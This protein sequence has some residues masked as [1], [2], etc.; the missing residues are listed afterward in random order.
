VK[1]NGDPL[2]LASM[3]RQVMNSVDPQVPIFD[4]RTQ[5]EQISLAIERE[6]TLA[7]LLAVF[8]IL[9]LSLA[10]VGIYGVISYTVTRR[11]SEMGIRLALGAAPAELRAMI[12]RE[13][14]PPLV[15]GCVCGSIGAWFFTRLLESFLFSVK[16]M[17]ALSIAG[18]LGV[19]TA[20]A[21]VASIVPALRAS[22]VAPMRALRYE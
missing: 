18:A 15:I 21:L 19:L 17:D 16:P 13:S 9:A 3:V 22:R 4:L 7:K 20:A 5:E 8:G 12:V 10:A 6:R 1:T 11:T 2:R 14:L